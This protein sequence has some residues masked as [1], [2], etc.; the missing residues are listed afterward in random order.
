MLLIR[1]PRASQVSST[2]EKRIESAS[3]RFD[4]DAADERS[5]TTSAAIEISRAE[6]DSNDGISMRVVVAALD[7][8]WT[9]LCM[10]LWISL[11]AINAAWNGGPNFAENPGKSA[12]NM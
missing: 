2:A 10:A 3:N 9:T 4:W 7:H 6:A 1:L 11:A 8:L 5:A 12:G